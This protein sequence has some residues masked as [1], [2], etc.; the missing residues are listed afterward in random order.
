MN[1]NMF[2]GFSKPRKIMVIQMFQAKGRTLQR[3]MCIHVIGSQSLCMRK[4]RPTCIPQHS[5]RHRHS[6]HSPAPAL[7]VPCV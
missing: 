3:S 1:M 2:Y 4:G 6:I 7:P 5:D